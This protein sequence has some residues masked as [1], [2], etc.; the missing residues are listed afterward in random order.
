MVPLSGLN[1]KKIMSPEDI[2][3]LVESAMLFERAG[4]RVPILSVYETQET[5]VKTSLLS[6]K[7]IKILVSPLKLPH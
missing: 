6:V 4:V 2:A 5:R 1:K 7:K 3:C